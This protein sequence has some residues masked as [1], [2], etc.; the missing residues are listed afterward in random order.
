MLTEAIE[1]SPL[2]APTLRRNVSLRNWEKDFRRRQLLSS[3]SDDTPSIEGLPF[4]ITYRAFRYAGRK[5][6]VVEYDTE[7]ESSGKDE[8]DDED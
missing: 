5:V 8:E 1:A 6:M 3:E 7:E 2:T 4:D